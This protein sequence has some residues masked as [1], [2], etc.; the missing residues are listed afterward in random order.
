M[1][2]LKGAKLYR[3]SKYLGLSLAVCA[4]AAVA[5]KLGIKQSQSEPHQIDMSS[6]QVIQTATV[7][8]RSLTSVLVLEAFVVANPL[9]RIAAPLDGTIVRLN[10]GCIGILPEDGDWINSSSSRDGSFEMAKVDLRGAEPICLPQSSRIESLLVPP[11]TTVKAGLPIFNVR[12]FG[13]ALQ[14]ILP[15]EKTY[16]LYDGIISARGE[17]TN[18][19]GPFDCHVLGTP[20]VPGAGGY[21]IGNGEIETE[22]SSPVGGIQVID[23]SQGVVVV[24]AVPPGIKL[25][26]GAPGLLALTTAEVKDAVV[27][28]IE[29]VAGISQRGQVYVEDKGERVLRN[30]TLGITDGSY[31]Q[32]TSGLRGGEKIILP[33]PSITNLQ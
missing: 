5:F 23:S 14:S 29:A 33:S 6:D 27:L 19:P 13:F 15:P 17:I 26:E 22:D 32:I 24:A 21:M 8:I 1:I 7:E 30:V 20:F 25:L 2:K 18:G 16:R 28:P 31:V 10:S 9:Y 12:H 4:V 11:G 3:I